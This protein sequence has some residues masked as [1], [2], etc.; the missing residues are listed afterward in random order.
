[1][2]IADAMPELDEVRQ[3]P[4]FQ[5]YLRFAA[6]RGRRERRQP[7]PC[8]TQLAQRK[9]G[10]DPTADTMTDPDEIYRRNIDT[11]R[12]LGREGGRSWGVGSG[13]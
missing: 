1:M 12:K 10:V 3:V 11:L 2:N 9:A 7:P 4:D 13:D 5:P 6:P 8:P